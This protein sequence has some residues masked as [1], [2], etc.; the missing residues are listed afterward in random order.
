[1]RRCPREDPSS[2][3]LLLS[4]CTKIIISVPSKDLGIFAWN[5]IKDK[6]AW[7]GPLLGSVSRWG[8]S[9]LVLGTGEN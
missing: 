5:I 1:M 6:L 7:L 2:G 9:G 3:S 8:G 4:L